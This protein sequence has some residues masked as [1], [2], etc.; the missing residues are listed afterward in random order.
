MKGTGLRWNSELFPRMY[1]G[2]KPMLPRLH[3]CSQ[4]ASSNTVVMGAYGA[5]VA[6]SRG[7]D[8]ASLRLSSLDS[9]FQKIVV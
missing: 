2:Y 8:L 7:H 6:E 1:D 3:L 4:S 9:C 5:L